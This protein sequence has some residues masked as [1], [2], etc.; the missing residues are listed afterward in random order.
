MNW[1]QIKASILNVLGFKPDHKKELNLTDEQKAKVNKYA[2]GGKEPKGDMQKFADVFSEKFNAEIAALKDNTTAQAEYEAWLAKNQTAQ[3]NAETEE[4]VTGDAVVPE[5]DEKTLT[6]S[7]KQ[8]IKA[9]ESLTQTN[10]QLA[11][12]NQKL[13][14]LPEDDKPEAV[15]TI[16]NN[17]TVTHSATHLFASN[18]SYDALDRPWNKNAANATQQGVLPNASTDWNNKVNIDK[19]NEDLGAYSRR[20]ANEIMSLLMDGYDIPKHWSVVTNIQDEYVFASIVTGEITQA[21]K[22]QFLPKNN[23]RFV[24]VINK[25][26]DKQIDVFFTVKQMKQLEKSWLN[27]FFNEGSTPF[28]MSFARY[29]LGEI[30]KQARKED[31]ITLFKGVY[32]NPDL[33]PDTAGSFMNSMSGLL[34]FIDKHRNKSYKAFDLPVLTPVNTYAVLTKMCQEQLPLDFRSLPGL[35]LSLGKEVHRWYVDG[36]EAAKGLVQ[37]YER[38]ARHIEGMMNI[39]FD[40]RPQLE[41]TGFVYLT[42]DNNLGIMVDRPGEESALEMEK[43][44]ERRGIIGVG[45]YKLGVF[46]KAFGATVDPNADVTYENQIFFSNNV[47]LLTDTYVPVAANDVTPSIS[48]HNALRIGANNTNATDITNFDDATSGQFVHVY[49]DDATNAPTI[50]NNTNI[51]LA[52]NAD[53]TMAKGDKLTLVYTNNKFIEYSRTVANEVSLEE[54]VQLAADATTADAANGT[55]FVTDA[56]TGATALTNIANA[57]VGETYTIEGGSSTNATTVANGGNFLLSAAFT[58]NDGSVLKV[59]YNGSKFVE[60]YRS[61]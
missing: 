26:Y 48:E 49:C 28:K 24:P 8:L 15:I 41:G 44:L 2:S 3:P 35:K 51:V 11:A 61:I 59:K 5:A 14:D 17:T 58:A 53:F 6:A 27:Q 7:I 55:W 47:E 19:I 50:K 31:K 30:F 20:N 36:R 23:Q 4:E 13:K 1:N 25:I 57:I 60:V 16:E 12:D 18:Q 42:T 56:N 39:E 29:L 21:F 34:K 10:A 38:D 43:D 45:D 40:I 33:V 37:D 54:K 52:D 46:V 32:S 22:S 9:N